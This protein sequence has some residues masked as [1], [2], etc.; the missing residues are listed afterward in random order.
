MSY[1]DNTTGSSTATEVWW[2]AALHFAP[3][4][5]IIQELDAKKALKNNPSIPLKDTSTFTGLR[6]R[7]ATRPSARRPHA[8]GQGCR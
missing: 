2:H 5:R 1:A 7:C 8:R 6:S 3:A 4:F